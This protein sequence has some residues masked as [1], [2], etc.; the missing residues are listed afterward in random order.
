MQLYIAACFTFGRSVYSERMYA[1][2]SYLNVKTF[3][4]PTTYIK[5]IFRE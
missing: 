4:T 5:V 3:I 2:S 1:F